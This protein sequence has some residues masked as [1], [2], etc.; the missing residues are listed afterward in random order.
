MKTKRSA[1][2]RFKI[3][4]SGRVKFN[5]AKMRHIMA[6]K[7]HKMKR[8]LRVPGILAPGDA[9]HVRQLLPYK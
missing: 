9:E 5:H 2:K 7:S 4:G 3:T 8:H 6:K 1:A